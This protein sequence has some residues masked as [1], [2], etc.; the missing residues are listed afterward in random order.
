MD[1]SIVVH[2]VMAR[3]VQHPLQDA[4]LADAG[5]VDPELQQEP[6]H[7][8]ASALVG[9]TALVPGTTCSTGPG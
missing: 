5:G 9:S 2:T 3:C 7:N 8:K 6:R 4:E 1:T